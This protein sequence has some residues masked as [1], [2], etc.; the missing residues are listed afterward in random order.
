MSKPHYAAKVPQEIKD[1]DILRVGA[2]EMEI[3]TITESINNFKK[4]K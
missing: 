2:Y 3:A 4:M 1:D